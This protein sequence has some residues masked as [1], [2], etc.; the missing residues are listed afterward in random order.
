MAALCHSKASIYTIKRFVVRKWCH[1]M[2]QY[3][4]ILYHEPYNYKIRSFT[5]VSYRRTSQ[6]HHIKRWKPTTSTETKSLILPIQFF[7]H[8]NLFLHSIF[9]KKLL[10]SRDQKNLW[11]A[12]DKSF[13]IDPS[14][15]SIFNATLELSS[16]CFQISYSSSFNNNHVLYII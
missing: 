8:T 12:D 3:F 13:L 11:K 1:V 10:I 15:L 14:M 7:C 16:D 5:I 9:K 6:Q 2:C 4:L